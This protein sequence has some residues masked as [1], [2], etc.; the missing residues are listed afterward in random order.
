MIFHFF[1]QRYLFSL[2]IS[3][4]ALEVVGKRNWKIEKLESFFVGQ[5]EI[6][7]FFRQLF[8]HKIFQ[9]LDRPKSTFELQPD[10]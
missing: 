3:Q 2:I 1:M 9:I 5:S 10:M 7:G 4:K 8:Q 6:V